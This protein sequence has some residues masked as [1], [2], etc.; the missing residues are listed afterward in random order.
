MRSDILPEWNILPKCE[1]AEWCIPLSKNKSFMYENGF[2]PPR[3]DLTTTQ[4][5]YH[6]GGMIFL[7]VNSF[8]RAVPPRQDYYYYYY[9]YYHYLFNF[10]W[11]TIK[12]T[13]RR[14]APSTKTPALS[15]SINMDIWSKQLFMRGFHTGSSCWQ[16]AVICTHSICLNI[17]D[18]TVCMETMRFQS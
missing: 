16:N 7:H 3:R 13:H 2:I 5:R 12:V 17:A 1:P 4:V 10:G 14:N 18:M 8:T 9:Y 6:Y 15:K 11:N